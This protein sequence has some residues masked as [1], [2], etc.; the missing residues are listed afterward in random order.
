MTT[1]ARAISLTRNFTDLLGAWTVDDPV[2]LER[3]RLLLLDGLAVALA[4]AKEPG[5]RLM[6]AQVKSESPGGPATVIGQ[7][8]A[9]SV[10]GAARANGMAMHVLDFE[11]MWN[12]PNHALSPLLPA[13]RKSI[14]LNSSHPSISYAVFCLKKKKKKKQHKC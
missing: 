10:A 1:D 14:R 12:P 5:P 11:P 9:T 3:C 7:G 6:A 8:F 2:L 4:G 13:D